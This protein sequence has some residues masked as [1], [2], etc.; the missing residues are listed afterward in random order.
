MKNWRMLKLRE[1]EEKDLCAPRLKEACR[2]FDYVKEKYDIGL[3]RSYSNSPIDTNLLHSL[4]A[5]EHRIHI[6]V[7]AKAWCSVVAPGVEQL[8]IKGLF[9]SKKEIGDGGLMWITLRVT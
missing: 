3:V 6:Y 4:M 7:N 1:D 9:I 8:G 5:I 2:L